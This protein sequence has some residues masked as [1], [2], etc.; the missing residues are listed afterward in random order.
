MLISC[1]RCSDTQHELG[2]AT[3]T[4]S[5]LGL[6][7]FLRKFPKLGIYVVMFTHILK[8]FAQISPVLF[9]F[10]I[11]FSLG[12]HL[13]MSIDVSFNTCSYFLIK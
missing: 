4:L 2:A 10:V 1:H 7:L 3:V 9:L 8:T 12:F 13:V 5:W 6:V 11:A